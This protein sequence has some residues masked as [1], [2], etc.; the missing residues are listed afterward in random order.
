MWIS[1]ILPPAG[2]FERLSA[3]AASKP[4]LKTSA[5]KCLLQLACCSC[6]LQA[7][8]PTSHFF[9]FGGGCVLVEWLGADKCIRQS[10]GPAAE[11]PLIG[12][13]SWFLRPPPPP[14]VGWLE[15]SWCELDKWGALEENNIYMALEPLWLGIGAQSAPGR[16]GHCGATSDTL[17]DSPGTQPV[18]SIH[19]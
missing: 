7:H 19:A 9:E 14:L 15:L 6:A 18:V 13:I 3:K 12:L 11:T 2:R 10:V 5:S 4:F 1:S 17:C 16:C 8:N